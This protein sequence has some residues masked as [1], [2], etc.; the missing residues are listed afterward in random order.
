ML[1]L[2]PDKKVGLKVFNLPIF[3]ELD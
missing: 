2:L 3:G 1:F